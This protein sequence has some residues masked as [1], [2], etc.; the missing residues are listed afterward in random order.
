MNGEGISSGVKAAPSD[1]ALTGSGPGRFDRDRR[2][3]QVRDPAGLGAER[4]APISPMIS[5][6]VISGSV[7]IGDAAFIALTGVTMFQAY[8]GPTSPE[9]K[10]VYFPVIFAGAVLALLCLQLA[11]LYRIPVLQ[12]QLRKG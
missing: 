1:A 8:L 4:R 9:L 3:G 5:P 10:F 6:S 2:E 7:R 11:G 12:R